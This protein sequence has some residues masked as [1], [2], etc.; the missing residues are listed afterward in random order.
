MSRAQD[1]GLGPVLSPSRVIPLVHT[2]EVELGSK[3]RTQLPNEHSATCKTPQAHRVQI[4]HASPRGCHENKC[5]VMGSVFSRSTVVKWR[6][7]TRATG[8]ETNGIGVVVW[9]RNLASVGPGL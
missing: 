3:H 5:T 8:V 2:D 9:G 4:T 6:R 1:R 7:L